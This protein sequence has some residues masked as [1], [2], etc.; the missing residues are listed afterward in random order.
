MEKFINK[1]TLPTIVISVI[2]V[3]AFLFQSQYFATKLDVSQ[4]KNEVL[5]QKIELQK[6]SDDGDKE[7]LKELDIKY[8]KIIT[9]LD[10]IKG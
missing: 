3:L 1:D 2:V 4:L 7:I 10:R 6:Y 5:Q 8:D 9:K